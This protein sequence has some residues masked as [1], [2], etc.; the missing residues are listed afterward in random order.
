MIAL[1]VAHKFDGQWHE[2]RNRQPNEMLVGFNNTDG[3]IVCAEGSYE[4]RAYLKEHG[5]TFN[6]AASEWRWQLPADATEEDLKTEIVK[7]AQTGPIALTDIELFS[8]VT[9]EVLS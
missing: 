4:R 1:I 2:R 7:L 9:D 5:Y 8:F 6:S 3:Y